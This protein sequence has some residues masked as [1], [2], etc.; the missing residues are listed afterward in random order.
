MCECAHVAC[1]PLQERMQG[2]PHAHVCRYARTD[3]STA[4]G[5]QHVHV[6]PS[7]QREARRIQNPGNLGTHSTCQVF[8]ISGNKVTRVDEAIGQ[9]TLLKELDVSG[10]EISQLPESL[11]TLPKL[12]VR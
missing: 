4:A 11:G 1:R 6:C 2:V 12:E 3:A 9:L 10:N 8:D 5:R 7:N